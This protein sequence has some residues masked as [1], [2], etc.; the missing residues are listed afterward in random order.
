MKDIY[1]IDMGKGY[2]AR[3]YLPGHNRRRGEMSGLVKDL[4]TQM[5]NVVGGK[6][7]KEKGD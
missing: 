3:I 5:E 6:E 1:E 4:V 7:K 2:G